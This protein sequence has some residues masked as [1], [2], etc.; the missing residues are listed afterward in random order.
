[1]AERSPRFGVL[2]AG[3]FDLRPGPSGKAWGVDRADDCDRVV[4]L[5]GA[6]RLYPLIGSPPCADWRSFDAHVNHPRVGPEVVAERAC[7]AR[8]R[9][10]FAVKLHRAQ[11]E[12]GARSLREH[13]ATAA[14]WSEQRAKDLLGEPRASHGVGHVRRF[15]ARVAG[16]ESLGGSTQLAR[17]PTRRASADC[18]FAMAL[19]GGGPV[20]YTHLRAHETS[21]PR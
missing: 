12:R 5:L 1:M 14:A 7:E 19:R 6:R 8:A 3:A 15:G 18:A 21:A 2:P 17:K 9:L 13:P 16:P 4:R 11:L 20:S 10:E